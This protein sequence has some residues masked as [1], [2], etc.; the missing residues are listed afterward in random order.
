MLSFDNTQWKKYKKTY[1][2]LLKK[3][4]SMVI[5]VECVVCR[6]QTQMIITAAFIF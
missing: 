4:V 5:N 3:I 2:F 1:W 6:N